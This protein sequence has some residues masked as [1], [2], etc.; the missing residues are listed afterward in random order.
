MGAR[1]AIITGSIKYI[2]SPLEYPKKDVEEISKALERRCDFRKEDIISIVHERSSNDVDFMNKVEGYCKDIDNNKNSIYDLVIFYYS[3]HG[4]FD[5]IKNTS[6]LQISDEYAVTIDDIIDC[7][8][9]V[10][11]KN[12]YLIID[13]CQSGG[14]SL[15]KQPKGKVERKLSYN[16]EG[17]YLLYGTTKDLHAFEAT[18]RDEIKRNIRNSFFTHFIIEALDRKSLYLDNTISIKVIDDYASKKTA[19]YTDF[20]QIPTASTQTSG[21]FPFGFWNT[22]D[23]LVD[24]SEWEINSQS[25]PESTLL[26]RETGILKTIEERI[27]KLYT[28]NSIIYIPNSWEKEQLGKLSSPAKDILNR[29]LDLSNKKYCNKP[30]VNGLIFTLGTE[31]D[32]YHLLECILDIDDIDINV[33]L[34]DNNGVTALKECLNYKDEWKSSRLIYLLFRRGYIMDSEEEIELLD[35]L[36]AN[37]ASPDIITNIA[38]SIVYK[39]MRDNEDRSKAYKINRF[40]LSLIS[41]KYNRVIGYKFPNILALSNNALNYYKEF[42]TIYLKACKKY[43]QYNDLITK[44]SFKKKVE[45]IQNEIP[46]QDSSYDDILNIMF[47]ELFE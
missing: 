43:N 13:A 37:A 27:I 7:V 19:Q 35:I 45:Q 23:D 24:I 17:L 34:K 29:K 31:Q 16:S 9:K 42:S 8:T 26:S 36:G 2:K 39:N 40:F 6:C 25:N 38:M 18:T 21:Y 12:T 5:T 46:F 28:E 3:G 20:D 14:F 47:P 15:M 10:K 32:R 30:L 22:A 11:S 41:L 33:N 4:F 1:K 44:P